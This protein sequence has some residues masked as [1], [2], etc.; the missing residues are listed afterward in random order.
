M[1]IHCIPELY[2]RN[3]NDC[4]CTHN[5]LEWLIEE[6]EGTG[7]SDSHCTHCHIR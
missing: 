1:Y 2:N 5:E 7:G 6:D 4:Y 3:C